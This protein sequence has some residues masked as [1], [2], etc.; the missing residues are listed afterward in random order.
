MYPNESPPPEGEGLNKPATVK[1]YKVDPAKDGKRVDP[2]KYERALMKSLSGG[3]SK[4]VS[5]QL[6]SANGVPVQDEHAE[7]GW[8]WTLVCCRSHN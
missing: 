5:Y 1:L 4:H 3:Q 7:H 6:E 8:V 2:S